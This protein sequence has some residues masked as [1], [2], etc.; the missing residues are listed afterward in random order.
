MGLTIESSEKEEEE[1][2]EEEESIT[3][4]EAKLSVGSW[5]TN[6]NVV[7]ATSIWMTRVIKTC[8][9]VDAWLGHPPNLR[10]MPLLS[11]LFP[12]SIL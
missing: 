11:H 9:L 5:L 3:W 7:N 2:E 8:R 6:S 10:G 12:F 4:G 1:E